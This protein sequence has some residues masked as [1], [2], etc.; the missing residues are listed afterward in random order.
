MSEKHVSKIWAQIHIG[1]SD[2]TVWNTKTV[3][4]FLKDTF[5]TWESAII[6]FFLFKSFFSITAGNENYFWKISSKRIR[7]IWKRIGER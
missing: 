3:R 2:W 4:N 1:G 7:R 5:K 6:L